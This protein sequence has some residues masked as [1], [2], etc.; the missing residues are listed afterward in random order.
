M[1]GI[2]FRRGEVPVFE[3][4]PVR[5]V[6]DL[7]ALLDRGQPLLVLH[8][9]AA[10]WP[11][12][13]G[14]AE[15]VGAR[16]HY[17][18]GTLAG[19]EWPDSGYRMDVRHRIRCIGD[20]PVTAGVRESAPDGFELDDELYLW[21]VLDDDMTPLLRSDADFSASSY[22]PAGEA[23]GA[24]STPPGEWTHPDGSDLVGWVKRAG[25][26]PLVY[27]QFG[28]GPATW[29]NPIFRRLVQD[30]VDWLA[31]EPAAEWAAA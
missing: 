11:A 18:P 4:P 3:P 6:L 9:A 24:P 8:H 10:A 14:W 26:S 12:W 17:Q 15:L 28:H 21:P 1:P 20:H 30:A 13:E 22:T 2:R 23:I 31:S 19:R 29:A 16:F 25:R 7:A 5:F 27:L